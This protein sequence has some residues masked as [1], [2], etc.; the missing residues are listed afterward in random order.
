MHKSKPLQS[1]SHHRLKT[2][3]EEEALLS[4]PAFRNLRR[5]GKSASMLRRK[6][7]QPGPYGREDVTT[8]LAGG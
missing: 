1:L 2:S 5:C 4:S 6:H 3:C 7:F 8:N